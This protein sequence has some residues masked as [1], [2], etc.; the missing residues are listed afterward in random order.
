MS[1]M[2]SSSQLKTKEMLTG[3]G[4]GVADVGGYAISMKIIGNGDAVPNSYKIIT[5]GIDL[6]KAILSSLCVQ[7]RPREI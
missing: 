6:N 5:K 7:G 3:R 2:I 4:L 1:Q